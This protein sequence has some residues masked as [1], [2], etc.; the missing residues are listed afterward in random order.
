M[1]EDSSSTQSGHPVKVATGL[2]LTSPATLS[3]NYRAAF[4]KQSAAERFFRRERL[5]PGRSSGGLT[6]PDLAPVI[7]RSR[8]V[9][10]VTVDDEG[11]H[12]GTESEPASVS[13]MVAELERERDMWMRRA[14]T[15]EAKLEALL[16]ESQG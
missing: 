12:P 3:K 9:H 14:L 4:N 11:G 10:R 6:P 2:L 13:R 16:R 7:P 15:A 8:E 1:P 5:T